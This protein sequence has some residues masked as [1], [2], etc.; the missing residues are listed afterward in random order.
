MITVEVADNQS[1]LP[2]DHERLKEA[3]VTVLQGESVPRAEISIA[4][5]DDDA[6][7]EL[8]QRYLG[9][10]EP[11]DVISFVLEQGKQGLEGEVIV[12][13]ETAMLSADWYEMKP[14]DELLLYVIHGTL[15]LAGYDDVAPQDRAVMRQR[16]AVY[17]AHFGVDSHG[18]DGLR[19]KDSG[20]KDSGAQDSGAQD[21]GPED[22]PAD[23]S[24]AEGES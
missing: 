22:A 13:A 21:S 17:L 2:L 1:K 6:I 5:V 4:V 19:A 14:E 12:S 20:A 10:D 7:T 3:V 24:P 15:H 16:E 11:T 9:Q 8:H 18:G 23:D